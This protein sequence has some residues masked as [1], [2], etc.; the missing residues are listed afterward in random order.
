VN[1]FVRNAVAAL[2]LT[3]IFVCATGVTPSAAQQDTVLVRSA[4]PFGADV[5]VVGAADDRAGF[6]FQ[7]ALKLRN[8][9][10]FHA[11][12]GRGEEISDDDLEARYLPSAASYQAVI[13]WLTASGLAVTRT[14]ENRV[15]VEVA[16]SVGAVRAALHVP[17]KRVRVEGAEYIATDA[18]PVV[19]AAIAAVI[20]G[21]NGLQPY[22]HLNKLIRFGATTPAPDARAITPDTVITGNYLPVGILRVYQA[23]PYL[24][25]SGQRT[26]TAILIDTF[27]LTSDLTAFWKL[28]GIPQSL[29]NITF[30]QTVSGVLPPSSAEDSLDTEWSSSIGYGSK[31]RVYATKDLSFQHLNT[32]YQAILSD[33][34]H[35]VKI[36]QMSVSLGLGELCT[37]RVEV[38]TEENLLSL[39]AAKTVSIFIASGDDGSR[40][41]GN[42]NPPNPSWPSTSPF[43]TAVGGTHLI[44]QI[45]SSTKLKIESE[46]GWTGSG[47]G[48]SRVFSAPSYQTFLGASAR[49]VPDVAADADPETGVVIV[50]DGS[51]QLNIGGTSASTPIWAGMASLIN[52]ARIAA[53]K[54]PLGQLN[55][56]IYPI[57]QSTTYTK[58]FHDDIGGCTQD[59]CAVKG[60]D[61]VTGMGSPVM[62]VLLPTLVAQP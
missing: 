42:S 21:I 61:L 43:V 27:P 7:V 58:N 60:Y 37:P 56:R 10:E 24:T 4:Q 34:K 51:K 48:F 40:E 45:I 55:P 1:T 20:E 9:E 59:F 3:A 28:A 29:N 26:T 15:T 57:L 14:Y 50:L 47:G 30:I 53:G 39:I 18:A 23:L 44:A 17:F 25:Q 33:L 49:V 19:P 54:K 41:C 16:G 36:E 52:Q 62:N 35:G 13:T 46:T 38:N 12:L 31:V 5:T 22:R 32:G 6:E 8:V 2:G 11:R